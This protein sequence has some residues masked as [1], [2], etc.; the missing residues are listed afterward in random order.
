MHR[1]IICADH[2]S[3]LVGIHPALLNGFLGHT[4]T[5]GF[6]FEE[7]EENQSWE[8]LLKGRSTQFMTS[9]DVLVGLQM[10]V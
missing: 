9:M 3:Y 4:F 8:K 5:P 6:V 7:L 1:K 10:D 2:L